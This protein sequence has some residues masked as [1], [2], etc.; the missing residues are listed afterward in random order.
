MAEYSSVGKGSGGTINVYDNRGRSVG[1]AKIDAQGNFFVGNL[2]EGVYVIALDPDKLPI[3]VAVQKTSIVAEV[4]IS[5]EFV[6]DQNLQLPIAAA[7]KE[8]QGKKE[9]QEK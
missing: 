2:R 5:K 3:E 1:T 9:T 6:Y 7:A 8:T 4:A